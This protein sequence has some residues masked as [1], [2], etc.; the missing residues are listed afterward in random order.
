M[1]EHPFFDTPHGKITQFERKLAEAGLDVE[2]IDAI[3]KKRGL[4]KAWVDDLRK[5]LSPPHA[6]LSGDLVFDRFTP[7]NQYADR[8]LARCEQR[9]WELFDEKRRDPLMRLAMNRE[10]LRQHAGPLE[11]TGIKLWLGHNLAY[12]WAEALAWLKDELVAA[13][14]DLQW[15]NYLEDSAITFYEGSEQE[16]GPNAGLVGL[17]FHTFWDRPHAPVPKEVRPKRPNWPGLEVVWFLALNPQCCALMDSET[18]PFLTAPGLV[19]VVVGS[20]RVPVFGRDECGFYVNSLRADGRWHN[21]AMVAFR[22]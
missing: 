13:D 1:A 6:T 12:N 20:E 7:V 9:G 17:D 15:Y 11:P 18:I 4:A 14:I 5:R 3:N 16:G 8:V 22:E 19:V 21:A 2:L 10:D